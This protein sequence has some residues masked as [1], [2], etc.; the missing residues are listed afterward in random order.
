[1]RVTLALLVA[2]GLLATARRADAY[3]QWQLSTHAERCTACHV[4]PGGGGLLTDFGRSE[5]GDTISRG[6]DGGFLHGL[7]SPPSWL[8]LGA[9][10]RGAAGLRYQQERREALAFPMQADLY[11]RAGSD[12]ISFNLTAGL[13]GAAREPRPPLVER[14]ASREHYVMWKPSTGRYVRAGRF[15]PVFGLRSQDHTAYVRRYLG[16]H[17]LEEPYGVAA[18]WAEGEWEAHAS[19]FVPQ[20]VPVL[21]SG[22]RARGAAVYVERRVL[23]DTATVAVQSR[24][25]LGPDDG[26]ALLGAVGKRWFPQA[27]VMLMGE[28][29]LQRQWFDGGPTRYQLAGYLG[30]SKTVVHGVMVTAALHRWQPDLTLRSSRDALELNVQYFPRAHFELHLLGRAQ[31]SGNDLDDPGLLT[32]LQLHYYL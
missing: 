8:Q 12:S 10:V 1:M 29:D 19:V 9:D 31:A 30:A 11:L 4:S 7:W 13:R 28:L 6:G 27:G 23:E 21:G 14:L 32:L 22:V 20:P 25:A 24:V 5:A 17:T 2:L 16:F 18:G 26:R 3:P 15:F